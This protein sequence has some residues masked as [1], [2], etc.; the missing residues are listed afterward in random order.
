MPMHTDTAENRVLI[1]YLEASPILVRGAH[2][3]QV[4]RFSAAQPLRT[5]D[6][7][8]AATLLQ[9]RFFRRG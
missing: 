4:Y 8:D 6:A 5:V 2:T 9:S 3:G 1:Q 7:C